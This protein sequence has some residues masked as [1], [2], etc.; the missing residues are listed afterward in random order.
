MFYFSTNVL[1]THF[2]SICASQN[3]IH[4][5]NDRTGMCTPNVTPIRLQGVLR[6]VFHKTDNDSDSNS[7]DLNINP[8]QINELQR[9]N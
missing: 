4:F 6:E 9:K 3:A 5:L 1:V 7:R 2:C 8:A